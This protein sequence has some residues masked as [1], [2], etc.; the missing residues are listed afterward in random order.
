M[1]I[2]FV[3][4]TWRHKNKK[5]KGL[6]SSS[7]DLSYQFFIF[8]NISCWVTPRLLHVSISAL[9]LPLGVA[10]FLKTSPP[11]VI[12]SISIPN[13]FTVISEGVPG[14]VLVNRKRS[15]ESITSAG[16]IFNSSSV[17][18]FL[19]LWRVDIPWTWKTGY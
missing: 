4:S 17:A 5:I 3:N 14:A 19:L 10:P 11:N 18:W 12:V 7:P 16:R 2:D 13:R 1:K 8:E 9:T 15:I 6:K